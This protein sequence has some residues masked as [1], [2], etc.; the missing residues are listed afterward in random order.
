MLENFWKAMFFITGG[1]YKQKEKHIKILIFTGQNS[2][3]AFNFW[4][5]LM[6]RKTHKNNIDITDLV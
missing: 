1:S 3:R 6:N 2:V 4:R 5:I